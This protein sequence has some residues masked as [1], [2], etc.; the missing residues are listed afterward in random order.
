MQQIDW[1]TQMSKRGGKLLIRQFHVFGN[2]CH[3]Q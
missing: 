2:R 1:A 3:Y